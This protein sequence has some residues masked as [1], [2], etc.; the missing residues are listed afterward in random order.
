[1]QNVGVNNDVAAQDLQKMP[2][3]ILRLSVDALLLIDNGKKLNS[4]RPGMNS[5]KHLE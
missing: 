5:G 2:P 3:G 1:M 4:H